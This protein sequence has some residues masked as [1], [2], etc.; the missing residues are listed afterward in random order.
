MMRGTVVKWKNTRGFGFIRPANGGPDFYV[1]YSAIVS[2]EPYKAL[3]EGEP[4]DFE[5]KPGPN[6]KP[7]ASCVIR[8][9]D[10]EGS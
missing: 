4:V 10:K 8:L 5:L 6:G 2:G 7:M 9:N 1:H 3:V